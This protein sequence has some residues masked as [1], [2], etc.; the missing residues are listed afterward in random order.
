M[1]ILT[2]KIPKY[3]EEIKKEKSVKL[4]SLLTPYKIKIRIKAS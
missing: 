2:R 1:V 3:A 4:P